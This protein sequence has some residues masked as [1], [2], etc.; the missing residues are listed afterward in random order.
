M[1]PERANESALK[2]EPGTPETLLTVKEPSISPKFDQAAFQKWWQ[3][4]PRRVGK[5]GA[6]IA[7]MRV[8]KSRKATSVELLAG[9]E[10]YATARAGEDPKFTK[11]PATWLN[12]ECWLDELATGVATRPNLQA[13][14]L[15]YD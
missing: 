11:H 10:R 8:M 5:G 15:I 7:Y 13:K 12:G 6:R 1:V 9:A 3:A 2:G 4:Y 14:D